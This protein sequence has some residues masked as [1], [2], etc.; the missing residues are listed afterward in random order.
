MPLKCRKVISDNRKYF[1]DVSR[2]EALLNHQIAKV[3]QNC[4]NVPISI[5]YR[6]IKLEMHGY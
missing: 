2:F 3:Q 1:K 4:E 5:E 6:V